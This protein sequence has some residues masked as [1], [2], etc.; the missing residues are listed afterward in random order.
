[1]AGMESATYT[2]LQ[3]SQ[4]AARA[5][6]H[7]QISDVLQA[8]SSAREEASASMSVCK[9]TLSYLERE[10]HSSSS[11]FKMLNILSHVQS[12]SSKVRN[13][14]RMSASANKDLKSKRGLY[15]S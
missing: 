1:M 6:R 14:I 5:R 8:A 2:M 9:P 13:H 12:R 10:F 3:M 4:A 15:V 7:E 11:K